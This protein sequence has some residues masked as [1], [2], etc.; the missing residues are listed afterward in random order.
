[1]VCGIL[2]AL[3]VVMAGLY[4]RERKAAGREIWAAHKRYRESLKAAEYHGERKAEEVAINRMRETLGGLE[5][6]AYFQGQ[7]VAARTLLNLVYRMREAQQVAQISGEPL[8]PVKAV[9]IGCTSGYEIL[10]VDTAAEQAGE[11][12]NG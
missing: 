4:A 8:R 1:I 10:I 6:R 5:I 7:P 11:V 2:A 12:V 3:L 9:E